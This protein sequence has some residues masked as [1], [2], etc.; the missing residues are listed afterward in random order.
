MFL[1]SNAL[2][3][4]V[5]CDGKP[6]GALWENLIPGPDEHLNVRCEEGRGP[7]IVH[8]PEKFGERCR[9]RKRDEFTEG[10]E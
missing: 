8:D 7:D 1:F 9:L 6:P 2:Q 3:I 4:P 5:G 10:D